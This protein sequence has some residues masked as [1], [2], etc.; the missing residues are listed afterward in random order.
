[1]FVRHEPAHAI[2]G[3]DRLALFTASFHLNV[4]FPPLNRPPRDQTD[5]FFRPKS[6]TRPSRSGRGRFGV[7]HFV[8]IVYGELNPWLMPPEPVFFLSTGRETTK[9]H[10]SSRQPSNFAKKAA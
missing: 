4:E 9:S 6:P 2:E 3:M 10:V 5:A 7:N 8:K 1:L